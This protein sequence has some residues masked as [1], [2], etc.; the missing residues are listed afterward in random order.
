MPRNL[1]LLLQIGL[2]LFAADTFGLFLQI[3]PPVTVCA[4]GVLSF[5]TLALRKPLFAKE[6][7]LFIALSL[8]VVVL[9]FWLYFSAVRPMRLFRYYCYLLLWPR[10]HYHL[11]A[12][13]L[14]AISTLA[15]SVMIFTAR[16]VD[17]IMAWI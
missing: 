10:S 13:S 12:S 2:T 11:G 14:T 3:E 17:T 7:G 5:A 6:R 1:G 4:G 8:V 15:Y 9:D 16:V